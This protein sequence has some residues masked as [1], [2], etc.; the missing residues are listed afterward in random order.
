[1]TSEYKYYKRDG[2]LMRLHI[3]QEEE[4]L[5]PRYDWDGNIGKM[6]CWHRYYS[7][8]DYKENNFSDNEDF[9]NDLIRNNVKEKSI[10]NYVKGKKASNGLE[11]K[12][13]KHEKMW[14]LW[15]TYYWFPIGSPKDAKFGIIEECEDITWLVDE[16]IEALPQ[17][18]KWKLLEKH[19]QIIFMPLFLYDHSEI[20]MNTCGYSCRWDSG[21]VG[22]I[23]TDKKTIMETGG[24]LQNEKGNYV[25]ITDR[26]WKKAAYQWMEGEVEV[27]DQYL[28][29][30]VY[31][32]ITEEYDTDSDDWEEKDSCWGF[33]SDKCGDELIKD[34]ALNFGVR[35]TLYDVL[36]DARVA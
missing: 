3:E 26:N 33:F 17:K 20:T 10:I 24:M 31:G 27:Y 22:Y 14:Q 29:G 25:K 35:E 36:N 1:M 28:Q 4:P 30:E 9:L 6:M 16:I 12:Y 23:Y 13:D 32:I 7:L 5:D 19:A 8:G 15:G 11:L 21:Q 18:D 34:V 2:K